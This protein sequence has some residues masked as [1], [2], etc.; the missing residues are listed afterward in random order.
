VV[1]GLELSKLVPYIDWSPFFRTWELA[2]RYP[3]ILTDEV[4]GPQ[5]TQL[6]EDAQ[7]MLKWIVDEQVLEARAT[8]QVVPAQRDGDD[9]VVYTDETRTD[10][11]ARLPMLRQQNRKPSGANL[12]LADYLAPA[13]QGADWL[14][15]FCVSAGF[16]VAEQAARFEADH[17]DYQAILLKALAD[18]LAEAYAEYLHEHVRNE[19]W[20]YAKGENFANEQLIAE[21]YQGIRPAPGYP[22]CPDHRLKPQIWDL[23]Q[24]KEH[25][26]VAL[27][28][29]MAMWPAASVSGFYFAHPKAAYF[30]VG[31]VGS[32]QVASYAKRAGVSMEEAER[33]LAP[34]LGY[35][36][37]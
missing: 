17:D 19:T 32:D 37:A 7:R 20:G 33:R 30:G 8:W 12:S 23:L 36:P 6:F 25:I 3:N 10:V 26:D 15:M 14:G 5:A 1:R 4:V 27:T 13:D 31:K 9:V 24:V 2:G 16:G 28:E 34:N 21:A 29:G 11:R 22:A 35:D 18:R